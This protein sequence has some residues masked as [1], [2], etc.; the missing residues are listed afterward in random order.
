MCGRFVIGSPAP[1]IAEEFR[2]PQ[3]TINI[4]QSFNITPS[5]D[6]PIVIHDGKKRIVTCKWG[7]IPSWAK[8]PSTGY[9]MIN[10]RSET[11]TVKRSFVSAFKKHRCLVLA[12]GFYEWSVTGKRKT[13]FFIH[14]K[15][16]RPFGFAG[17]YNHW[18]SGDGEEILTCTIITTGAN[19]LIQGIHQRMPVIIPSESHDLWLDPGVQEEEKL[20]PLL[21]P[22][23][24]EEMEMYEVSTRVNS[25]KNNSRD[26][27]Q[28]LA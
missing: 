7:F 9:T 20:L 19:E 8:N 27:I 24:H 1:L 11:I 2:L 23:P 6:I 25:P 14:L 10:A 28:P 22:Y 4:R 21:R 13:P 18:K 26:N 5:Q 15:S 16:R 3:F 17:L 12:D